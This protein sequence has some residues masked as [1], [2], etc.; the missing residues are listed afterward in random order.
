MIQIQRHMPIGYKMI[1][2]K[3][4]I[5]I[6]RADVIKNIF[7]DFLKGSSIRKIARELT[8]RKFPNSNNKPSWSH[9]SVGKI[10]ENYKYLGD[11]MYLPIIDKET[12]NL[13]QNKRKSRKKE[14]GMSERII[15]IR[16]ENI[17]NEKIRCGDCKD[18][19]R[20]YI[21][22]A[23]K[24]EEKIQWKCKN[25]FYKRK[26]NCEGLILKE[27]DIEDIFI[28]GTNK[29]LSRMWMLNKK[30]KKEAPKLTLEI[31]NLEERIKELEEEGD[32]S[33]KELAVLIFKRAKAY[34]NIC[35][36]DDYD[37]KT[38]KIK[39]EL[40]Y[41]DSLKEFDKELFLNIVKQII[42]YKDGRVQVEYIN[43]IIIEEEYEEIRKDE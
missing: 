13:A 30:I 25:Y 38:K 39:K 2:G 3:I 22:G 24:P 40:E 29:L 20:Q 33:S 19:Y 15:N 17:F 43:G 6:E 23:G 34:Y 21:A 8:E 31:R 7:E 1:N 41:K 11:E 9:A 12:F 18:F 14:L 42:I 26:L 5:D 27:K 35:K 10:L 16:K 28:L 37:Y 4:D 32:F 36:I